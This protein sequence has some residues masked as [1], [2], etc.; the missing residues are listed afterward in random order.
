MILHKVI[1]K[2]EFSGAKFCMADL[3]LSER[4]LK[5]PPSPCWFKLY[6]SINLSYL[7]CKARLKPLRTQNKKH[8]PS[9][10]III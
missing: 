2:K 4:L 7:I 5:I 8:K 9:N 6:K 10:D 1:F 3:Y